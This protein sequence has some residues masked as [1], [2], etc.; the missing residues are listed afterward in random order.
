MANSVY[1]TLY[2]WARGTG[3]SPG[4]PP[5]DGLVYRLRRW[6]L[7]PPAHRTAD[8]FRT[9]SVMSSRPVNRHWMLRHCKL[10]AQQLDALLQRLVAQGAIEA[11][12][13]SGYPDAN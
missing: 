5:V 3:I 6:P 11:V 8:V 4:E 12:D 2:D 9:L 10:H 7:L 1:D 13:V